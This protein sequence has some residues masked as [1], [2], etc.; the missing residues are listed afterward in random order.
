MVFQKGLRVFLYVILSFCLF[1]AGIAA[2]AEIID[3]VLVVVNNEVVT[4]R[5]F[6]KAFFPIRKNY[7]AKF[8]GEDMENRLKEA[9]ESLLE[10]LVNSK[11]IIS[12]AK[13]QEIEIDEEELKNRIEKI[14]AYYTSEEDFLQA[15]SA[16]GTNLTEFEREM[17]EQ[18]LAQKF[19]EKEVTSRIVVTPGEIMDLYDK[20][21]EKFVSPPKVR[22]RGIMIRKSAGS[23]EDEALKKM[24][25]IISEL[26]QG[27]DF[28]AMAI[29]RSEGPYAKNGGDMGYVS[30]GQ[31]LEEIDK[32]IFALKKGEISDIVGTHI[33]Y[34]VFMVEDIVEP[35]ALE[36]KEVSDF[37]R[38][39]LYARKFEENME[40][41]L[42]QKR[43][44]A[45][46]SQK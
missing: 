42:E 17:R 11:L 15:L 5:E 34:H 44:N 6:D 35:R 45:Y 10:Q 38:E 28:A 46:I 25:E 43:K 29:E 20:N 8:K 16:K 27:G 24:E 19:V 21:K 1:F 31:T 41:W 14:K 32:V 2:Y 23:G 30:P 12:L 4:Q 3:K 18:M 9:K 33:G 40:K 37:L 13:E 39:Q 36:L 22:V 7:E 26:R